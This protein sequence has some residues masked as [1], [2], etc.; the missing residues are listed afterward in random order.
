MLSHTHTFK[1]AMYLKQGKKTGMGGD[2]NGCN[3]KISTNLSLLLTFQEETAHLDAS[4]E[5][6][7]HIQANLPPCKPA[8][9]I[10]LSI[11]LSLFLSLPLPLQAGNNEIV[12][13]AEGGV[14]SEV[15]GLIRRLG[16]FWLTA[17]RDCEIVA[18]EGQ[19][20]VGIGCD[21]ADGRK[22]FH[23]RGDSETLEDPRLT[24]MVQPRGL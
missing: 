23:L 12:L 5:Q 21:T 8:Q 1:E 3:R 18:H 22:N 11:T 13:W 2:N 10:S 15:A 24:E 4:E 7:E 17:L 6:T 20:G 19:G 16:C 9:N 14:K